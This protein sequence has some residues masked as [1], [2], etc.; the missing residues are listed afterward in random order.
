MADPSP[1]AVQGR[2]L[3]SGF[4]VG[5]VAS[6]L[7]LTAIGTATDQSAHKR[8]TPAAPPATHAAVAS[9]RSPFAFEPS[10]GRLPASLDYVARAGGT[11]VA[12]GANRSV[13]AVP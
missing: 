7:A 13:V 2:T 4:V 12:I 11:Q 8:P 9:V 3:T 1:P 10:A 5:V 6:G